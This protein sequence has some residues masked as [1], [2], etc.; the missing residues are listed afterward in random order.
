MWSFHRQI[1]KTKVRRET[2]L[3]RTQAV[4]GGCRSGIRKAAQQFL[5][6]EV[7]SARVWPE[8]RIPHAQEQHRKLLLPQQLQITLNPIPA[9]VEHLSC[10][11]MGLS[12][13]KFLLE[14]PH[15]GSCCLPEG[16]D[17]PG[18]PHQLSTC[19]Q[20]KTH[21]PE[22]PPWLDQIPPRRP[23]RGLGG[24]GCIFCLSKLLEKSLC[25]RPSRQPPTH[26][27]GTAVPRG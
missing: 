7:P 6:A 27:P 14:R 23:P 24:S 16:T 17:T 21:S 18:V 9:R 5:L 12:E 2:A 15:L 1:R 13:S 26:G 4:L 10:Q 19:E 8:T 22:K 20:N 3:G 11:A 25:C